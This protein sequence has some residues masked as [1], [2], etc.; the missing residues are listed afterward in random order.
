MRVVQTARKSTA[1]G[2]EEGRS[3][4]SHACLDCGIIFSRRVLLH[5]HL[6]AYHDHPD[7]LL[8]R[9]CLECGMLFR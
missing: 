9:C 7:D 1:G 4:R 3:G 6:T 8:L 5:K 2:G